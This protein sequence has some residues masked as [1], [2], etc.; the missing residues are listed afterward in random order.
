M[1]EAQA[2]VLIHKD[3]WDYIRISGSPKERGQQHGKL[4]ASRICD[5]IQ[6]EG[7]MMRLQTGMDWDFFKE[8]AVKLWGERIRS[9]NYV[10]FYHEMI[11]IAEGVQSV[12]PDCGITWEDILTWNAFEELVDYWFPT[13][14]QAVYQQLGGMPGAVTGKHFTVGSPDRCS[15]FIA[16]GS[17]TKTGKIVAAHNSFVPFEMASAMNVIIDLTTDKG[18]RLVM[19]AQPGFIHSMS[20]FYV[21]S[22]GLI[23]TETTIGGFSA[24]NPDGML[25]C[26]RVRRAAQEADSLDQFCEIFWEDNTGGYANTWLVGDTK[27]NQIMQ[28]EAGCKFY[29]KKILSD[30]YFVGFNAPQDARIRNFE[31]SN[32]GYQDIRRHQGARQVR[33]PQLME[34]YKGQLDQET[35]KKILADHYDVYLKRENPCS[36]TVCSHYERDAREYMSQPGRPVP[37]RPQG[38]VDGVVTTSEMAGQYQLAARFGSSCGEPFDAE[39]FFR[40]HPQFSEL[41]D[42]IDSRPSQPWAVFPA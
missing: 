42:L 41:S 19:Q 1:A 23:I 18:E 4:L 15:A 39:A 16:T 32:S 5:C 33:L 9:Y 20:D 6:R 27:T 11:G 31:T 24:Y 28:F 38:A 17:Y 25:E 12:L 2:P 40:E 3:G 21:T 35:A 14:A 30:G 8:Q 22:H 34:Q 37:F 13:Q 36:R 26:F 7:K 10:E 29:D